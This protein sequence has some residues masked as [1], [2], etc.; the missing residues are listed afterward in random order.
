[1]QLITL[2]NGF[3]PCCCCKCPE[4][5]GDGNSGDHYSVYKQGRGSYCDC[6][7][8]RLTFTVSHSQLKQIVDGFVI[9]LRV[10]SCEQRIYV[11]CTTL[12]HVIWMC[13]LLCYSVSS[14]TSPVH[15][16]RVW[17]FQSSLFIYVRLLVVTLSYSWFA[18]TKVFKRLYEN[19]GSHLHVSVHLAILEA[20]RDVCKRVVKELTSWVG[21]SCKITHSGWSGVVTLLSIF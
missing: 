5:P 3:L 15:A 4:E 17:E 7:E 9:A 12:E 11:I 14:C 20:I 6:S 19:T 10:R 8:G 16:L 2:W 21:I 1:M 13:I 18:R